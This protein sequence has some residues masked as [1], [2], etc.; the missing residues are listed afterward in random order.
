MTA[1]SPHYPHRK[2]PYHLV[3]VWSIKVALIVLTLV[4]VGACV[5]GAIG[6]QFFHKS[7]RSASSSLR[8]T[9]V[10]LLNQTSTIYSTLLVSGLMPESSSSGS[11]GGSDGGAS[12]TMIDIEQQLKQLNESES[13]IKTVVT[14]M[15]R[16]NLIRFILLYIVLV[17]VVLS[18][19][20]ALGSALLHTKTLTDYS[21]RAAMYVLVAVWALFT[22]HFALGL[23]LGDACSDMD[24][25]VTYKQR[26]AQIRSDYTSLMSGGG[27]G[28]TGS[29][30]NDTL[31]AAEMELKLSQLTFNGQSSN[32]TILVA[33]RNLLNMVVTCA[34]PD[35][36]LVPSIDITD[37]QMNEIVSLLNQ[38]LT[39]NDPENPDAG[40]EYTYTLS[41]MD[42]ARDL[43]WV[44]N[45]EVHYATVVNITDTIHNLD[46]F[47]QEIQSANECQFM[48]QGYREIRNDACVGLLSSSNVL[49]ISFL[50]I[51]LVMSC[52]AWLTNLAY[53][54]FRKRAYD[55]IDPKKKVDSGVI[56]FQI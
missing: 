54:R 49:W 19:L 41:D 52:T 6:N 51:S 26:E 4:A 50:I 23:V 20:F 32:D 12:T 47:R 24:S 31:L 25:Y 7:F 1:G 37:E 34:Q 44:R 33:A 38:Y 56:P 40:H 16:F 55:V 21:S 14:E 8:S 22:A 53:K 15:R 39:N 45:S 18:H 13:Q 11:G 29:T 28:G 48:K 35:G 27:G 9:S 46:H 36:L 43:S 10:Q 3:D 42:D 17:F 5:M 30:V 2:R